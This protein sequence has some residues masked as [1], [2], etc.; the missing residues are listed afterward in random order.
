[1]EAPRPDTITHHADANQCYIELAFTS[2]PGADEIT[3]TAP[4]LEL[5]PKGHYMIFVTEHRTSPH[6]RRVPSV[7]KF[8]KFR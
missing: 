7:A 2:G 4:I 3:V 1:M 5:A 6:D 8:V